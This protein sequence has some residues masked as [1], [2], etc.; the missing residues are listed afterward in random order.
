[1]K[2]VLLTVGLA[3][4]WCCLWGSFSPYVLAA[5]VLIAWLVLLGFRRAVPPQRVR[6][7]GRMS[8]WRVV[9]FVSFGVYFIRILIVANWQ[10]AKEVMTPA[11][12]QTPRILA[13]PVPGLTP[14]EVVVLS[15]AITLTP[16]TLV[17]DISDDSQ[18]LYVHCLY[19]HDRAKAVAELD[20]LKHRLLKGVF[21][22]A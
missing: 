17:V 18:T 1:M 21:G 13:Y 6:V 8:P 5:G 20:D 9:H 7:G 22:H 2:R 4:L 3:F 12:N 10:V 15:S 16:G 14:V 19:A 11:H